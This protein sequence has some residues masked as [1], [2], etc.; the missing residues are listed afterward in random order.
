MPAIIVTRAVFETT[1]VLYFLYNKL[2][3]VIGKKTLDDIDDV[4]MK[5]LFGGR[6]KVAP[7]ESYNILTAINHTDK[8]FR[9]Y[10]TAYDDLSEFAHPNWSGVSG[11]YS[12]LDR[13]T[14]I[15]YLGK[16]YSNVPLMM[17]LPLL[18]GSLELFCHYYDAMDHY[19]SE[20]NELCDEIYKK[21]TQR[22]HPAD[23]E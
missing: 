23:R 9:S 21:K 5:F 18:A 8:T 19:C 6:T 13:N 10:R 11:A 17:A 3:D 16:K 4:L 20:F 15:L 2:K 7:V 14:M 1:A 12:K 22:A